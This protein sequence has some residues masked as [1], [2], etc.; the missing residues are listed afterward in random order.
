[1]IYMTDIRIL[2]NG[3]DYEK[4][5]YCGFLSIGKLKFETMI[6]HKV[7]FEGYRYVYIVQ[8]G[9]FREDIIVLGSLDSITSQGSNSV[10]RYSL[11]IDEDTHVRFYVKYD[12]NEFDTAIVRK[13]EGYYIL[14]R[15]S[16]N[17]NHPSGVIN[18]IYIGKNV[19]SLIGEFIA[20]AESIPEE[21][22]LD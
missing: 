12:D 18:Y 6:F 5:Y 8:A 17:T 14:Q 20:L 19:E 7:E 11:G 3:Y 15:N 13:D 2:R 16:F 4:L 1:M 21:V 10:K 22:V 9:V